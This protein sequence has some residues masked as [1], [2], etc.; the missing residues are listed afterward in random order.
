MVLGQVTLHKQDQT[1]HQALAGAVFDLR[2]AAGQ[3]VQSDLQTDKTG[4]IVVTQLPIGDYYFVETQAPAGYQLDTTPVSF[5]IS[6]AQLAVTVVKYNQLRPVPKPKPE[7]PAQP[8]TPSNKTKQITTQKQTA[9]Q[10]PQTSVQSD[11]QLVILGLTLIGMV[12]YLSVSDRT[13]TR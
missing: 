13:W 12:A 6:Q 11:W 4:Q 1:T 5:T 7:V 8:L 9:K 3:V 2:T 10:L